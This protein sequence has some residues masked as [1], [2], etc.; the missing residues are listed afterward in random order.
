LSDGIDALTAATLGALQGMTEF[1]PVSSSGHIAIAAQFF[2]IRENSL[3][4]VILLHLGTLLAT[5]LLFRTDLASLTNEAFAAMRDPTRLRATPHGRTLAAIAI[6]TLIT[7]VLGL[8]LRNLAETFAE[9]LHLV[10]YGLLVSAAFLMA[11]GVARDTSTEVSPWQA[12]AVGMAQGVA[13]L[14]G[15]SRSGVTIAVAML[16]GVEGNAAFRFS[17][18]LS[19]PAIA[20]A[21]LLEASGAEGLGSLGPQAW[22]G[23]AVAF[24]TGC[25]SLVI[26]RYVVLVGRMWTFAIYLLPLGVFL[27]SH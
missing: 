11:S 25:L 3:A 21:A 1:L 23:G 22:L 6:A 24:V 15:V 26:L 4:L 12:I 27:I 14:P 5:I 9:N 16:V 19:L 20:G 2:Q 10:G 17:F 18:L 8:L 13:V 7:A